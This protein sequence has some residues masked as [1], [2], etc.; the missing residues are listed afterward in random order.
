MPTPKKRAPGSEKSPSSTDTAALAPPFPWLSSKVSPI[1]SAQSGPRNL[2]VRRR[3][4]SERAGLLRRLG[5]S[6]NDVLSRLSSYLD[7]EYEPFHKSPLAAEITALVD[8]VFSPAKGR[9]TT[10]QP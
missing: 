10:L 7:W 8:A 5:Y 2:E 9:V 1:V 4:I 6:R 3:E